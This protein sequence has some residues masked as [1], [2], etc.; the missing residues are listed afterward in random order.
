MLELLGVAVLSLAGWLIS[1]AHPR[2]AALR[3]L[4]LCATLASCLLL[5]AVLKFRTATGWTWL[6]IPGSDGTGGLNDDSHPIPPRAGDRT[7]L[8]PLRSDETAVSSDN[9]SVLVRGGSSTTANGEPP[10][11]TNSSEQAGNVATSNDT[12][13]PARIARS[14]IESPNWQAAV[15]R[16]GAVVYGGMAAVLL[17]RLI[18][19]LISVLRLNRRAVVVD[20]LAGDIPVAEANV[21]V[22]LALGFGRRLIVLPRGFRETI[23]A[24]EL[25]DVLLGHRRGSA[26]RRRTGRHDTSGGSRRPAT[27]GAIDCAGIR[28]A[29]AG[30]TSRDSMDRHP[31]GR[32]RTSRIASG[33]RAGAG[34]QTIGRC[35][36]LRS[37]YD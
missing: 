36:R 16:W 8:P 22:P 14:A 2:S 33:S 29:H 17:L 10:P 28:Q 30:A 27:T 31:P 3:H 21:V 34:R 7:E 5:P 15:N 26:R 6:T 24:V 23:N 11:A 37:E 35:L 19:N 32:S 1:L 20:M 18:A 12:A 25:R 13:G 9:P 4:V